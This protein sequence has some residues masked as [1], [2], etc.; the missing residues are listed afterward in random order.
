MV[1]WGTLEFGSQHSYHYYTLDPP[2][3]HLQG[4]KEWNLKPFHL[5][6]TTQCMELKDSGNPKKHLEKIKSVHNLPLRLDHS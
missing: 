2:S 4:L 3:P 1:Y 6:G 5:Q